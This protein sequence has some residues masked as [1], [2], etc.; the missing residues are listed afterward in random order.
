MTNPDPVDTERNH[1]SGCSEL[2]LTSSVD[3]SRAG[4]ALI[5]LG[6]LVNDLE[7]AHMQDD[8]LR[9]LSNLRALQP[10]VGLLAKMKQEVMNS[11]S[12]IGTASGNYL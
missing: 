8:H 7:V 6:R 10:L 5:E 3:H 2:T 11:D 9:A 12:D 4:G 1:A